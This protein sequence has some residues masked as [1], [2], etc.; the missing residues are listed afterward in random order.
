[1][2]AGTAGN[3]LLSIAIESSLV[4]I[5]CRHDFLDF[6]LSF[7]KLKRTRLCDTDDRNQ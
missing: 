1:L 2:I 7:S 5:D 3:L 6:L 4:A